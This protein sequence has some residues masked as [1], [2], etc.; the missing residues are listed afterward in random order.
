MT[1]RYYRFGQVVRQ[2]RE[3]LGWSQETLADKAQLNRSYL[4]ELERGESVPSLTTMDKLASAF[5]LKLSVLI[6]RCENNETVAVDP[7][8]AHQIMPNGY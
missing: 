5:R 4:G 6:I 1:E 2:Q 3:L 7:V 8:H